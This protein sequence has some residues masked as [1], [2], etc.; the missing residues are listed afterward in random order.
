MDGPNRNLGTT[1]LLTVGL[2][3]FFASLL[4]LVAALLFLPTVL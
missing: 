4:V 2:V 3:V 1:D